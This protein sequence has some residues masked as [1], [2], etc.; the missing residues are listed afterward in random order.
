MSDS[1]LRSK[2]MD[3]VK[4]VSDERAYQGYF[5]VK[6]FHVRYRLFSGGWSEITARE[7]FE[8]GDA[9][10]VLLYDPDRDKVALIEQFRIG[11][12]KDNHSPWLLE[13]V[14]GIIHDSENLEE[15]ARRE[16]EEEAGL[17]I[18]QLAPICSCWVSPGGCSEYVTLFCGKIDSRQAGG[19]HGLEEESEDIR[20]HVL[21]TQKA[22]DMVHKGFINN[23]ITISSLQWWEWIKIKVFL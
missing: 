11:A 4:I 12:I 18:L 6:K 16:T 1:D 5:H 17:N 22:F 3:D 19:I 2:N 21:T 8:R 23:S 7:V 13:I 10:G 14:A 20:V 15:V 9:V